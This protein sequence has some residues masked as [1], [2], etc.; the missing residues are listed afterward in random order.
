[1]RDGKLAI[2]HSENDAFDRGLHTWPRAP[3]SGVS[4][5]RERA[6]RSQGGAGTTVSVAPD[7]TSVLVGMYDLNR[8][9]F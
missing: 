6:R 2:A 5:S 1:M 9:L 8:G 7:R 4:E 3:L